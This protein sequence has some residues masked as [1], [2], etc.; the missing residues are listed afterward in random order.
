MDLA[1]NILEELLDKVDMC[2][3]HAPAAVP[4]A[5]ELIEGIAV[6]PSARAGRL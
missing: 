2:H 1:A 3:D 4:L 6:N 5:A